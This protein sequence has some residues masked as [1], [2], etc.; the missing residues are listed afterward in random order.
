MIILSILD[1][2]HKKIAIGKNCYRPVLASCLCILKSTDNTCG[3]KKQS[4]WIDLLMNPELKSSTAPWWFLELVIGRAVILHIF[5]F[6]RMHVLTSLCRPP[7][8]RNCA[9]PI[10]AVVFMWVLKDCS[11]ICLAI[12]H[13]CPKML[14]HL[15]V[16]EL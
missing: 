2:M 10:T 14:T 9:R 16:F 1:Y 3:F 12:C 4:N 13:L 6:L 11:S 15:H 7:F 8:R 5:F